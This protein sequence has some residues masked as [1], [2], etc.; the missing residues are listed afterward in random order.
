[1]KLG[2]NARNERLMSQRR[3][4]LKIRSIAKNLYSEDLEL[5]AASM[6][7]NKFG[8]WYNLDFVTGFLKPITRFR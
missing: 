8:T 6:H 7:Y 3:V 1:M 2:K 4:V 5:K